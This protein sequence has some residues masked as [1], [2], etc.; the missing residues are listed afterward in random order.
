MKDY[1]TLSKKEKEALIMEARNVAIHTETYYGNCMQSV[2]HGLYKAFPDMGITEDMLRG[3]FGLAGGCGCSLRGTCGALN[4]AAWAISLFYG[5]PID[6][7][8]GDYED[9]H[10]KIR[11]IMDKFSEK[12]QGRVLCSDILTFN[13]GAPYDWKTEQGLEDYNAH[14]GTHYCAEAAAF[15]TELIA[16][17]I[18]NG[19]LKYPEE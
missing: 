13:M 4:G 17:M 15:C 12:Y 8:P 3:C 10:A 11:E 2:L 14:N 1:T 9:C 19:E 18:V 5:R 7:L 16:R 6:D